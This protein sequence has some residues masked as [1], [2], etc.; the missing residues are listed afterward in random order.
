MYEDSCVLVLSGVEFLV[1]VPKDW[2]NDILGIYTLFVILTLIGKYVLF[3][4][5]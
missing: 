1:N 3:K 2:I 4:D 5:K